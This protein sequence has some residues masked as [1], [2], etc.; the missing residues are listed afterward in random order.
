MDAG[1]CF[2]VASRHKAVHPCFELI[3]IDTQAFPTRSVPGFFRLNQERLQSLPISRL[4]KAASA[5]DA[6]A[7][8][9]DPPRTVEVI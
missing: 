4:D 8:C 9:R 3:S 5:T 2:F 6:S 1:Q 7:C